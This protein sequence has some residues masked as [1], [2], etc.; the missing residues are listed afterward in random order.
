MRN[1]DLKNKYVTYF[2]PVALLSIVGLVAI[3]YLVNVYHWSRGHFFGWGYREFT[4]WATVGR[5]HEEAYKAGLR[6]GDKILEANGKPVES[7]AGLRQAMD[8]TI[9]APN[10]VTV[11]RD[12]EKHTITIRTVRLGLGRAALAYCISWLIGVIIICI[13]SFVFFTTCLENK[14]WSFFHFCLCAG[15]FMIF[16]Y[17]KSLWPSWIQIFKLIGYCFL[18]AAILHMSFIFPFYGDYNQKYFLY[19]LFAYAFSLLL[20]ITTNAFFTSFSGSPKYLRILVLFYLFLSIFTFIVTLFYRYRKIPSRLARLKIKVILIG[21]FTS[22]LLPLAEPI[23]NILFSIFIFPNIQLATV[24]FIVVFPLSIGYAIVK[25][26]LF[27]IDVFI[28]RTAGY[29]MTTGFIAV[30]YILFI[31]GA[32]RI[33]TRIPQGASFQSQHIFNF[34]FILAVFFFFN[35]LTNK[36]QDLVNRLFYRR[37]YDYKEPVKQLL[38]DITSIFKLDLI[39]ERLQSILSNTMF[40][41]NIFLFLYCAEK[42]TYCPYD[43]NLRAI[44]NTSAMS[45]PSSSSL[46]KLLM[47]EKKEIHK[48]NFSAIPRYFHLRE[49]ALRLFESWKARLIIPFVPHDKMS[50][51]IT[52]GHMKSGRHYNISDIEILRIITNQAAIALENVNLFQDRIEKEKIKEELKIAGDIQKRM[53]PEATPKIKNISI[54]ANITP[55]WE[56]GG[57]FYDFIEIPLRKE[58]GWGIILGDVTGHGIPGALLMSAAHSI[59]QNQVLLLKDVVPVMEEANRLLVRETKK[60]AFVAIIFALL[61]PDKRMLISNAGHPCPLYYHHKTKE[62]RFLENEGERFPL[63]I[64]DDPSYIPLTVSPEEGDVIFFYTDGIVEAKNAEGEVFGYDRLKE[65]FSL[66][67]YLEPEEITNRIITEVRN[68]SETDRFEADDMTIITI[69]HVET[70][71]LDTVLTLPV[72]SSSMGIIEQCVKSLAQLSRLDENDMAQLK[73]EVKK[74]YLHACEHY[75]LLSDYKLVISLFR[76]GLE[77]NEIIKEE[78][79]AK[80]Y[81]KSPQKIELMDQ[82]TGVKAAGDRYCLEIL[83]KDEILAKR[84]NNGRVTRLIVNHIH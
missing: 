3:L 60:K 56:I 42:D 33:L 76:D 39:I 30:F 65:L 45:I 37:K 23:S 69:K 84:F 70:H 34:L 6:I 15:L 29:L 63:G 66:L 64:I 25:H 77:T 8:K 31:S 82:P 47:E 17:S 12:G 81:A 68:F 43:S 13:G 2:V 18:P 58:K 79:S 38:K 74:T 21:F 24:P 10:Q 22:L 53:L 57:D 52:L 71:P 80:T 54:Y 59:C 4:G 27:E 19:S 7:L 50:G 48:D 67:V 11:L 28:K 72:S 1:I 14:R 26:D 78:H 55:S 5:V 35:P 36:V 49:E 20:F 61:L 62:T 44:N 73:D 9:G 41:E 40:I 75:K 46:A 16:F 51:F 83:P 32:N